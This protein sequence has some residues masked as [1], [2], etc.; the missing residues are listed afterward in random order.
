MKISVALCTYNGEEYLNEQIDSIL[1]QTRKVDEIIIC[2]DGSS[3]L[4]LE[5]LGKYEGNYPSIFKTFQNSNNLRSVKN[6]EKAISL[7]SGDIVFLSDQDD[8]WINNKVEIILKKFIENE[9]ID[10]IATN[11]YCINN[12]SFELNYYTIWDIPT[13]LKSKNI[14]TDY[15]KMITQVGNFATG[16]SMAL[17]KSFV[18]KSIPFPIYKD[19]HH[20]EWIAIVS[21][22]FNTFLFLDDKLFKY[23]IHNNQQVGGVCYKKNNKVLNSLLD[24]YSLEEFKNFISYK[25]R[26]SKLSK[27]YLKFKSI[28]DIEIYYKEIYLKI[29]NEIE[30]DYLTINEKFKSKY[31]LSSKLLKLSDKILNKRQLN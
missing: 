6:F 4:T 29:I 27:N 26:I 10:V 3:D 28:K 8:I 15:F 20:D 18:K 1:N 19:F 31:P 22:Y 21:S 23:R 16:A 2:D 24:S 7:C 30:L 11:G 9:K 5:I 17:R 14:E 13:I 25:R 12:N